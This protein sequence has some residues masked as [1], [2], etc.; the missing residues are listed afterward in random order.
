[1]FLK[2]SKKRILVAD[3]DKDFL[4]AAQTTLEFAGFKVDVVVDGA[5]ALEEIKKRRYDLL[6]I[7]VFMPKIDGV[8]LFRKARKMK[9]S[10][11][12]PVLFVSGLVTLERLDER[13]REIVQRAEAYIEKPFQTNEFVEIARK[14][15]S[16]ESLP[17]VD[18]RRKMHRHD[19]KRI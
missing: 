9:N 18:S 8:T 2:K 3:D 7:D 14:L 1:M 11:D 13:K 4:G 19:N 10:K 17:N 16:G 6:V 12:T 15:I 5:R